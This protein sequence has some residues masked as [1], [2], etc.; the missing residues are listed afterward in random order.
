MED[1][2][3]KLGLKGLVEPFKKEKPCQDIIGQFSIY[4]MECLR[5]KDREK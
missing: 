3:R 5:V 4:D 1:I 2:L